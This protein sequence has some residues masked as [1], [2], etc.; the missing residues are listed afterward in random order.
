LRLSL[1]RSFAAIA[2]A[3]VAF[4]TAACSSSD[5]V[6]LRDGAPAYC[7]KLIELPGG[8]TDAV[9]NAASGNI[10][11]GDKATIKKA[12]AQLREVLNDNEAPASLKVL[13]TGA[14]TSFDKL[15]SGAQFDLNDVNNFG[16]AFESLGKAVDDTCAAK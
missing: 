4:A 12:A 13:L 7:Q 10:S 9:A 5:E 2:V 11:D 15:A 1:N 14:A 6:E 16:K 8:L 3:T